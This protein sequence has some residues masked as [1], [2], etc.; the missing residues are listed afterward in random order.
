MKY[1]QLNN[2]Q[3]EVVI[4]ENI[5][6][7]FDT[8]NHIGHYVIS[9][10]VH[11]NVELYKVNEKIEC[12]NGD[13]FIIPPYI[14]H[15]V[16][17]SKDSRLISLCI[18]TSFIEEFCLSMAE[19]VIKGFMEELYNRDI[20]DCV[21]KERFVYALKIIYDLHKNNQM[22]FEDDIVILVSK[23][24]EQSNDE[25]KLDYLAETVFISKYHLIRKFKNSV[26]MT[27]HQFHI[28]NRVRKAQQLLRN[29][30]SIIETTTQMGFYDQSHFNKNFSKV[31][32]IS[33][34]E[35]V[36]SIK[37]FTKKF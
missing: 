32:G 20:I 29:G 3:I 27:P 33:P 12:I 19:N 18:G 13:M 36:D 22:G 15:S 21:Q 6:K 2:Y 17:L 25:L 37:K 30:E 16:Y 5:E 8:H 9:L 31:V 11:G 34:S 28:Q 1:F 35:Y 4:S 23:I 26:G 14:S 7:K 10:L 24:I